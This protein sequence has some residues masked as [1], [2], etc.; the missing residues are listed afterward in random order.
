MN[1]AE[2]LNDFRRR[3]EGTYVWLSMEELKKETLVLVDRVEDNSSKIGVLHLNSSEYGVLTV[4]FGSSEHSLRF[5]YPPVGVFQHGTQA[6]VFTRK[7]SR[8]Y[9]RGLCADNS[10]MVNVAYS[11]VGRTVR[12]TADEVQSAFTHQVYA[13]WDALKMLGDKKVKSVALADD[14]SLVKSFEKNSKDHIL[15]AWDRPIAR[16]S[17]EGKLSRLLE[18]A[19]EREVHIIFGE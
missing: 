4:N 12:W 2:A 13:V 11:F 6:L 16:I 3:Y 18:K 9:R 14:Y 15:F 1:N 7:P 10:G 17:P 5:K 8:Q 19:Y